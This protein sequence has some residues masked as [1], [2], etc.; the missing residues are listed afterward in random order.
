MSLNP[1]EYQY[2]DITALLAGEGAFYPPNLHQIPHKSF[3]VQFISKERIPEMEVG[4]KWI[5]GGF[6]ACARGG[7]NRVC[8]VE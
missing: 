3:Y 5:S 4:W 1:T 7:G 8:H 2:I 6:P